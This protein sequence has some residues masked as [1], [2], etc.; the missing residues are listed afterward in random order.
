MLE[1]RIDGSAALRELAGRVRAVGD[2]GLG[3]QMSAGL[4]RAAEDVQRS[5]RREYGQL[6]AAG[7]Y[8]ALFSRSLRFRTEARTQALRASFRVITFADGA[9]ERRDIRAV[10]S[11]RLR[12][13]VYGRS[14]RLRDGGRQANPWSVTS[15]RGGFHRRGTDRAADAAEDEMI[16]VISDL[17]DRLIN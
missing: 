11:G 13:P 10:E 17:A 9:H 4:R 15:V 2:A 8:A 16:K 1:A 6:P 7:G 14:R 12:H 3:R 5:I